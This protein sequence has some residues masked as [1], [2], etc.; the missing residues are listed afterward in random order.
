MKLKTFHK[1]TKNAKKVLTK[2][3]ES[4]RIVKLSRKRQIRYYGIR[5]SKIF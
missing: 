4:G 1:M 5:E 3:D 2:V